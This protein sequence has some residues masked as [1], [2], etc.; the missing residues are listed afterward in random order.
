MRQGETL[1]AAGSSADS[2]PPSKS[3]RLA[4]LIWAFALLAALAH[5]AV[6]VRAAPPGRLVRASSAA[7]P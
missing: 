6:E 2:A 4:R 5:L 7:Q 3:I 1:V